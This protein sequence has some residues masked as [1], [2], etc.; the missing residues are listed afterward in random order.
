MWKLGGFVS[1]PS[2][3]QDCGFAMSLFRNPKTYVDQKYFV[4]D[5]WI[6]FVTIRLELR[7][8]WPETGE[9]A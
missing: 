5:F 7:K 4:I 6:P 2:I 3:Y 9:K 8:R 1:F